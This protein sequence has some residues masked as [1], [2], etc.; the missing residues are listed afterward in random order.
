MALLRTF[1]DQAVI[2]IENVR[3][4]TEL[5][6][7][8]RDLTN[9]LEQQTATADVL[10]VMSGSATDT[11]PVFDAIVRSAVRLCRARFA[12][13]YQLEGDVI[14]FV[15][16]HNLP[17][18]AVDQF[19]RTF[20][21]RLS[22]SGTLVARAILRGEVVNVADI[23]AEPNVS[24]SVRELAL[25]SG[26]RSVLA[27][28][29]KREGRALGAL[30]ITR[31]GP[32]GEPEPFSSDEIPLLQ[33]FTEQAGIA[34]ENVR[35]FNELQ[36][37]TRDLTRSVGE[38]QALGEVSQ[39][40]SSTLDLDAVLETIVGRA[41]QL[42]G[43][44]Q[45]VAYEFDE[46]SQ[47]FH[48]RAT[49]R[50]T[51]E[52]IE[53]MRAAPI[54]LGE[55]AIGR[56][57]VTRAPIEVADIRADWELVAPQAR[58][59]L[60][61]QGMGSLLAVPLVR[62]DRLLGGL[63]II[64]RERG[65]FSPEV[66]AMLQT[67]ATQSVLAIQN[68]R[69]FQEI[70]RQKQYSD[71]LV[72]TS[73]V[74]IVTMDFDG[75]VVGWNP[76]AER[77]FGYPSGEAIGHRMED[78]IATPEL[79][80]E[81]RTNI[82]QILEGELIRAIARRARKD[83]TMVDV[84]ISAMPVVVDGARVGM[85]AIYHD[86]TE[87]LRARQEAEA[88]NEA[89]SAFLA[90]MSHE[91]RTPMNAV[92]GMSG[93]LLNTR[94]TEEQRDYA[95]VIRN[96]GDT[97]LTVINDI[98]DFSKIEAGKLE[99]EAQ[100]FDLRECVEGAL[101]L[102][103][104]RAAE[105]G[106]DLA[107]LMGDGVPA[108]IV[109]DVTRLRQVLLNLLS[110]AVKFTERGEVVLSVSGRRTGRGKRRHELTFTVRDTGIGIPA[111]RLGRLFQ[112]FSQV[113]ASTTRRYGGTGLGL[114]ISQR[115]TELMGGKIG[116]TSEVGTGSEFHFTI[117]AVATEVPVPVRRDLS[118]VQPSLRDK[119]VLV[120]D[121]NA[122]NRRIV[123]AHL[124]NW[125]M[126]SRASESPLEALG[127]IR[128]GERF[129][130]AILDMHMPEMDGVALAHA[131][132]QAP[133]GS[134]LPLILFTSLGR[135]EAHAEDEGFAAY[136]HKPIKPSQLFDALVSVVADQPVHVAARG[137]AR[138]ELDPEMARRH[139]LRILLAEDNAV[140]QKVALRILAQMGYRADVA[141]NGLEAI[142][143]VERQTYDVVL[144]DVQ[145]PELDGF[146]ASREINRR[147]PAARPRIVAMTANAMQG[148]REL[149][150]AA[151]MDDYVAKPIR[152]EELVAAL[153][154]SPA[155]R[156]AAPPTGPAEPAAPAAGAIDRAVFERLVATTGGPFV[157]ELIDTFGE[158]ARE[159][160]ATL[161]R[162]LA[163]TDRDAF[164]RAAHSLKS[165][166]E[167]L[168]A[169]GLAALA[170]ELEVAARAGSLDGAGARIDRLTDH[171]ERAA[172]ALGD[173]RRDLTA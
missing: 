4:F 77:L 124:D 122:T 38:L 166:A 116:V 54:R 44:D 72:E 98:L 36:A 69:L 89:K 52:Y 123:T 140:N 161:R 81:V 11:Q 20:P 126:P 143:A 73:P 27:V 112:S 82:R 92:I 63:V 158:D 136:L 25:S 1:A 12:L 88:A 119:R 34:I 146:E 173:L 99:L 26:Y 70:Q 66:V 113:D 59:R 64:R 133:A 115:L 148:D 125:G 22:E 50:M 33:T 144:M 37:R 130:V 9:A 60:V 104:T 160:L 68:A 150:V 15:T 97:L 107:Y 41:V 47:T 162:T 147:W 14:R 118:G 80:E 79:R 45:G 56:A 117:P 39:A 109:G 67:F 51:A 129:D 111:D 108:A 31:S 65:A 139:P 32:T 21:Q 127:W 168:G 84:E 62:E 159:L 141:A 131:I 156:D 17:A 169:T 155:H 91:I 132:R 87:L 101:D 43:S 137:A 53:T 96:S 110:N 10:R 35:L 120:V 95:E 42:S 83:S 48:Q 28:P 102:V 13:V 106:I 85:I 151:G 135:R 46:K 138:S 3:L 100:P 57:G 172:S 134:S 18:A 154:R 152:V 90:T 74:A 163:A 86:I 78:L 5:D 6:A 40:V 103:A 165:T 75:M 19:Q 93:L 24:D 128:A 94:L 16:H 8:N 71:T 142:E 58:E 114:A 167:S 7:R 170:R 164:R 149:C 157:A 61:Q 49:H 121:D 145:M 153:E 105:K 23:A 29:I 55:G 76:G 171:Y 30:A 2:A